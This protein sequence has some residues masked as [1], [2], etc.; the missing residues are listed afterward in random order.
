MLL[1]IME[2][3]KKQSDIGDFINKHRHGKELSDN[4]IELIRLMYV[5]RAERERSVEH[6]YELFLKNVNGATINFGKGSIK[7]DGEKEKK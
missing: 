6:P 2:D 4:D 5:S 7:V 3:S 1:S